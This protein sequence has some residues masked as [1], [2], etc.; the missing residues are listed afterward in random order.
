MGSPTTTP[1]LRSPAA[2]GLLARVFAALTITRIGG[3]S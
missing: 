1:A 3:A 2:Q